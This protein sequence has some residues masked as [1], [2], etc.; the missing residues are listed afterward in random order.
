LKK[1]KILKKVSKAGIDNIKINKNIRSIRNIAVSLAQVKYIIFD[2][3]FEII[4]ISI[5]TS[6]KGISADQDTIIE[7]GERFSIPDN[8][9]R[10]T[11]FNS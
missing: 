11:F 3:R 6:Y 10:I 1:K 2:I 9:F 4:I 5:S 7:L 8:S